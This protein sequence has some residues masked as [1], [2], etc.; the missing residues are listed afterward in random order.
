MGGSASREAWIDTDVFQER[1]ID[2]EEER[3]KKC[4]AGTS[5]INVVVLDVT[6][7]LNADSQ[8]MLSA[9]DRQ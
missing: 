5:C 1:S 3:I 4:V 2:G 8:V 6:V 9:S 7:Y